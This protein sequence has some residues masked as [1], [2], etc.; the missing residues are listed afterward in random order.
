MGG[1]QDIALGYFY[2]LK[3]VTNQWTGGPSNYCFLSNLGPFFPHAA[4]RRNVHRQD[5]IDFITAISETARGCPSDATVNSIKALNEPRSHA[6]KL[7]KRR[8][9]IYISNHDSLKGGDGQLHTLK[10]LDNKHVSSKV[11]ASV[12]APK[13]LLVKVNAPVLL[14]VNV[15]RRLVN[16][17]IGWVVS[18]NTESVGVYSM[19]SMKPMLSQGRVITSLLKGKTYLCANNFIFTCPGIRLDYT[20]VSRYDLD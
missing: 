6:V 19:T 2:Q 5:N 4:V 1:L 8:I 14:T 18:V 13:Q 7:C 10:S 16:G 12:D 15:S 11:R 3:P 9:E 17:L 20:K